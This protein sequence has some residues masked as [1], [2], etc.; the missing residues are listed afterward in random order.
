MLRNTTCE[1]DKFIE[2]VLITTCQL[3]EQQTKE[4]LIKLNVIVHNIDI[5]LFYALNHCK[6]TRYEFIQLFTVP[7]SDSAAVLWVSYS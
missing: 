3:R 7:F 2:Q 6:V 4:S 5:K 1:Y